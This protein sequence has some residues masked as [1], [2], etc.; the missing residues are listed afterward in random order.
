MYGPIHQDLNGAIEEKTSPESNLMKSVISTQTTGRKRL[1]R[2][3]TT[4]AHLGGRRGLHQR[5]AIRYFLDDFDRACWQPSP[6]EVTQGMNSA[7]RHPRSDC[8]TPTPRSR[9]TRAQIAP[10]T[11]NKG[12]AL[13]NSPIKAKIDLNQPTVYFLLPSRGPSSPTSGDA[14]VKSFHKA[15]K[16]L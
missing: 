1:L 8:R 16:A 5:R 7:T 9:D 10:E 15:D 2:T 13:R 3:G 12:I 6:N 11:G 4:S 14:R